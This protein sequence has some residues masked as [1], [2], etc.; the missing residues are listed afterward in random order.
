M[1]SVSHPLRRGKSW[2]SN[3]AV[4]RSSLPGVGRYFQGVAVA[5]S[6]GPAEHV[7]LTHLAAAAPGHAALQIVILQGCKEREQCMFLSHLPS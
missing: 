2:T 6:L 5:V 4:A 1:F 3:R 7:S